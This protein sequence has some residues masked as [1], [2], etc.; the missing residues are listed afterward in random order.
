MARSG[1][2]IREVAALAG[3]SHQTVSRVI[4]ASE[5]VR[6]KTR[7]KVEAAIQ[8]LG[9]R[10]ND[11]ARIMARGR[12]HTLACITPNFTDFTFA[13][14]IEGA[15]IEAR[16]HGYYLIT[17]SAPNPDT[18]A[19]LV[20]GLIASR[21]TDGLLVINPYADERHQALP[22]RV[23]VVFLGAHPR[24]AQV[25]TVSL[26]D[27]LGGRRA[28]EHLLELGHREIAM[29]T[30][31]VQEDCTVDRNQGYR[32]SLA[33][34]DCIFDPELIVE[35][36]WSPTSGYLGVQRL[37][38]GPRRFTAVFAQNDRMAFGAINALHNAGKRVPQAISVIGFDDIPMAAYLDP[39]L[40]TMRQDLTYLGSEAARLLIRRV[41]EPQ[42]P[43][44][45]V[46]PA[47]EL[48][49]RNSTGRR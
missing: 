34:W 26:D 36:D 10:P 3:V 25:D 11:I 49:L 23:P 21:R 12:A 40:T 22:S 13:G 15:E 16:R 48:V 39:P 2:T 45:H 31:P 9:Y 5:R 41:E 29:I 6:P 14:L 28:V 24:G 20:D 7:Q 4:N 44:E 1:V 17:S 8:Q 38:T 30:G 27:C 33:G 47:P 46:C 35:G 43:Y 18:F 32:D 19:C 37:L 42:A